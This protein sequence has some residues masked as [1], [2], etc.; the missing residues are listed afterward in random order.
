MNTSSQHSLPVAE[1]DPVRRLQ[2]LAAVTLGIAVV[3]RIIDAPFDDVWS[4][5]SDIEHELPRLG[6]RFVTSLR[7]I[8]RD[9][10]RLRA[11]VRGPIGIRDEFVIVLRPGW[12]WMEG[13]VLS[14]A[15][16]ARAEGDDTLFAWATNLRLPD[17][18][19]RRPLSKRSLHRTLV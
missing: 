5:A 11:D 18:K 6:A 17:G 9:G 12:C 19:L 1:L 8:E 13:H 10:E 2:V 4:I 16:V 7:I 3:E 14:A 15:M